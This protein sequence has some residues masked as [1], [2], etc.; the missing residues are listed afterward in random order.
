MSKLDVTV[1]E[2]YPLDK[3]E[4][5]LWPVNPF[6]LAKWWP[7]QLEHRRKKSRQRKHG[8]PYI[9]KRDKNELHF[10]RRRRNKGWSY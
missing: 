9:F 1:H 6:Q 7:Q 8:Q 2:R 3:L 4:E 10:W 5:S